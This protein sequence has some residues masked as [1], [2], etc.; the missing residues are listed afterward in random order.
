MENEN[1]IINPANEISAPPANVPLVEPKPKF[2]FNKNYI[3]I[4]V[5]V[6]AVIIAGLLLFGKLNV[7]SVLAPFSMKSSQTVA[8]ETLKYINENL[9]VKG[10]TATLE[11]VIQESGLLKMTIKVDETTDEIYVTKDGKIL[12]LEEIKLP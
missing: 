4:A 9:I 2:T 10:K 7:P 3:F 5:A 1:P 8:D 6:L 12:F 11:S